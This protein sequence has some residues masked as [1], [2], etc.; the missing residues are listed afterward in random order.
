[1]RIPN[2]EHEAHPWVIAKIAPDFE[3]LDV[4]A[5]PVHGAREDFHTFLDTMASFDPTKSE[6]PASRA[7]IWVRGRLGVMFGWDDVTTERPIPGRS[8]TTLGARLPDD[9]RDGPKGPAI[10]G[11]FTP[12]YRTDEEWAG[13]ISNATVHGVLQFAWVEQGAGR[14]RADMAIYVKPRGRLGTMYLTLIQPFRH[15]IVYPALTRQIERA[16]AARTAEE[17]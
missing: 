9:L 2:A 12:L 14:Y 13:E 6:S 16:W 11:R 4:W 15:L 10:A 17:N 3:L 7:L 8:E 1:M 5:L